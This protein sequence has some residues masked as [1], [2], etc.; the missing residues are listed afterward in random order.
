MKKTPP[1]LLLLLGLLAG[2]PVARIATAPAE[3]TEP[4][5][6]GSVRRGQAAL[7][8]EDCK[9]KGEQDKKTPP[10]SWCMPVQVLREFFGLPAD[11]EKPRGESLAELAATAKASDYDLRFMVALVPAP[12]DP[13]LDQA[14]MPSSGGSRMPNTKADPSTAVPPQPD[15]YL[16]DRIWLPWTGT[17]AAPATVSQQAPGIM[18]FR[19]SDPHSIALVFLVLETSKTGDPERRLAR[20]PRP[21]RR[22][23]D[24]LPRAA[25]LDPG[26][27]VLRLRGIV[28]VGAAE[29]AAEPAAIV[30]QFRAASGS[31]TAN[32]LEDVFD[33]MNVEL[34]PHR[35]ARRPAARPGA[36]VPEPARWAGTSGRVALLTEDDTSYGQSFLGPRPE[37]EVKRTERV[38]ADHVSQPSSRISAMPGRSRRRPGKRRPGNPAPDRPPRAGPGSLRPR[39]GRR[40]GAHLQPAD[41]AQQRPAALEPAGDDR[42]R[43]DP[44]RRHRGDRR[45]GQAF[46]G[47]EDPQA[48]PR[49]GPVHVRQQPPLRPSEVRADDGRHARLFELPAVHGRSA[50]AARLPGR[51]PGGPAAAVQRRISAGGLRGGPLP[52]GGRPV[53]SRRR[54]GSPPSATAR[55]GR[56][57]VWP[58]RAQ[59]ARG[60]AVKLCRADERGR[61]RSPEATASAA[62]SRARTTCRSCWS[63]CSSACSRSD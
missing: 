44:L 35:P 11:L 36:P 4:P 27:L 6:A 22:P 54:P 15:D 9:P 49:R 39:A 16:I 26:P 23:A 7:Q 1:L 53:P 37:R 56:S 59:S 30:L 41:H 29:L 51:S 42:A 63:P 8:S 10:H 19:G 13:R 33:D 5:T 62:V 38:G 58:I 48:R 50:L 18:L 21:D 25:G 60:G 12:P 45:Q 31:A 3:K 40:S 47:G 2:I 43:G 28:A 20:V 46:P 52:A 61:E 57:R 24:G 17:E 34:L 14:W 32:G 55:S